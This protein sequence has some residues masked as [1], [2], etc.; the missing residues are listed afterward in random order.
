ML[1]PSG[2]GKSTLL[3]AVAGLEPLSA[4][5]RSR[6]TARPRRRAHPPARLRA[7]VPGRPALPPPD[8]R[9][10]RRLRAAAAPRPGR[11][12]A[13]PGG[14][15][16]ELVGLRGLRRPAARRPCRA[17]SG[18][19]S[20]WPGP[21]PSSR[22]CCCSTSRCRRWTA[23]CASGSPASCARSCV[24]AGTTALLVTHDHEE[25]FALADRLAVMRAGRVVQSGGDRRGVAG[26]GGRGDRA[27]PRLRP[28]AP[29]AG[30]PAA[31]RRR[32]R[33]CRQA[34]AAA[35]AV[36]RSALV[37]DAD[38]PLHGVVVSARVTPEQVRLVVDVDG[39]GRAGR[40]GPARQPRG[41]GR[42]RPVCAVDVTRLAIVSDRRRP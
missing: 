24:A 36:R 12:G 40:G 42:R 1:G 16:L 3:R 7:D 8:R 21:W 11:P 23:R 30:R 13:R 6:S 31:A 32:R 2:C 26:P 17:A 5:A 15:L 35:V 37:V 18:S 14:E 10:Q 33:R 27:V 29:R 41:S 22:G 39:L 38:G 19:G 34:D 28:G 4:T 20:R 25:A 9:A